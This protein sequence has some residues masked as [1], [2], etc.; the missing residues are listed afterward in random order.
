[1]PTLDM[2]KAIYDRTSVFELWKLCISCDCE[3]ILNDGKLQKIVS[4]PRRKF[5]ED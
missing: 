4:R 1:M 5:N 3:V 2:R